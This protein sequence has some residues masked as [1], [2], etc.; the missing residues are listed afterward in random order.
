[1]T[2]LGGSCAS[3]SSGDRDGAKIATEDAK[4]NAFYYF[5]RAS[6][7]DAHRAFAVSAPVDEQ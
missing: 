3:V 7:F 4:M 1:M 5:V 2:Q 6:T